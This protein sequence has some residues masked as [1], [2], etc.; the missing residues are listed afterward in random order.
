MPVQN[1]KGT[2]AILLH[3]V[4][5]RTTRLI[6]RSRSGPRESAFRFLLFDPAHF[7]MERK[8]M[9]GI[10]DRAEAEWAKRPAL[11]VA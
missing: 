11:R 9:L 3:P 5:D 7:I 8:M 4:G 6:V 2:W 10:R 1:N